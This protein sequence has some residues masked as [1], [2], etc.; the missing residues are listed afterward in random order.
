M[1]LQGCPQV[2]TRRV[3][4]VRKCQN[5]LPFRHQRR[6]PKRVNRMVSR[7]LDFAIF[8]L[9]IKYSDHAHRPQ[10]QEIMKIPAITRNYR[11]IWP[12]ED[13]NHI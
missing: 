7:L 2:K 4:S 6:P 8:L 13:N 10:E 3:R 5:R 12:N 1:A 9:H 11:D